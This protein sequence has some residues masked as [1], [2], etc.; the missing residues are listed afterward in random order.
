[1]GNKTIPWNKGKSVNCVCKSCNKQFTV[2][3]YLFKK[4]KG[5]YCSAACFRQF[6][7]KIIYNKICEICGKA[8]DVDRED[9]R[10]CSLSCFGLANQNKI[11]AECVFCKKEFL[12]V[13]S[14]YF[15]DGNC[16]SQSCS[17]SFINLHRSKQIEII[18]VGCGKISKYNVYKKDSGI[19]DKYCSKRCYIEKG[20]KNKENHPMFG[21]H[22]TEQSKEKMSDTATKKWINGDTVRRCGV[23]EHGYHTSTKTGRILFYRS[24]RERKYF[25]YLDNNKMVLDYSNDQIRIS[26]YNADGHKRYY[27][28]DVH[29]TYAGREEVIEIKPLCQ[30]VYQ[31]NILKFAAAREYCKEHN[32]KFR[33]LTEKY[34]RHV[35]C[36]IK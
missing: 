35:G 15:P 27:I 21:R 3:E 29:V 20:L 30:M 32:L 17:S 26:Y 5:K 14:R 33:V 12:I 7:K 1:M 9:A 18:C 19:V 11:K 8:F 4:G 24:S 6:I 16:C 34:L 25:E 13:P 31:I 22:H 10:F 36:D 28:P 2:P 23:Y